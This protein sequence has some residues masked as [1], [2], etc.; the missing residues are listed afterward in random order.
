MYTSRRLS[1]HRKIDTWLLRSFETDAQTTTTIDQ[2]QH[3]MDYPYFHEP[4]LSS[5]PGGNRTRVYGAFAL[6]FLLNRFLVSAKDQHR[7]DIYLPSSPFFTGLVRTCWLK[8]SGAN[9]LVEFMS[10][11]FQGFYHMLPPKTIPCEK[12]GKVAA[13]EPP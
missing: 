13:E 8:E 10:R 5:T 12:G 2:S 9:V 4:C 3:I 6:F 11:T 1:C 7:E